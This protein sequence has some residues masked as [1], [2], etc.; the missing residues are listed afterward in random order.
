M[1]SAITTLDKKGLGLDAGLDAGLDS[2]SGSGSGLSRVGVN[3]MLGF[4]L[5]L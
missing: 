2:G 3:P 1:D 5:G 4:D